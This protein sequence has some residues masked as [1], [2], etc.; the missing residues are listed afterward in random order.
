MKAGGDQMCLAE[1]LG[2]LLE[3]AYEGCVLL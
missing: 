1:D 2:R 3:L